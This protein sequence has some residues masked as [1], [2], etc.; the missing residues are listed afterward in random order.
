MSDRLMPSG[1]A[2]TKWTEGVYTL[3]LMAAVTVNWRSTSE[4]DADT[5]ECD[6]TQE[7]FRSSA[8]KNTLI[9]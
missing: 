8:N 6:K 4:E 2:K 7:M 5:A 9:Q 3:G 1:T